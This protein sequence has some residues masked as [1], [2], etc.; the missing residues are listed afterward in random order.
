MARQISLFRWPALPG[1]W[2]D[3]AQSMSTTPLDKT[4]HAWA[5]AAKELWDHADHGEPDPRDFWATVAGAV[6]AALA[7]A[8]IFQLDLALSL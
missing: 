6:C 4:A 5:G 8:L 1:R 2:T 3:G 7:Q